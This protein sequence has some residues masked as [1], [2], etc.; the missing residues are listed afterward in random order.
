MPTWIK[1]KKD[2]HVN[3][4]Q[5]EVVDINS[6]SEMQ[7][8]AYNI[9]NAHFNN[10]SSDK[11]PLCLIIIGVA[12]T[13]K[14]YLINAIRNLLQNRCAV[15]A[16]TGKAAF[17]I[18]GVTIHSLLKLPIGSRG[19]KY[20]TGQSLCRLQENING[21][22]YIIIDEYSMLGQVTFGW[23]D[24]RCKQATGCYNKVLGGKSLILFGDPG[25]LPPVADKPLYHA[26]PSSAVGEQIYQT[27]RMFDKVVKLTVN[28]RVQGMSS[29]QVT[30][31]DLLLRLRK[32]ESTVDDWKLL[33]T[34]QPSAIPDLSEFEDS[35]R[36]FYSNEQ[37]ANYN[38]EELSKLERPVAHI[39]ARHSSAIAKKI[40]SEDMSGLEP[41]VFLAKG[42]RVMLT[43]N[44]WSSVGLCNEA[45]G[46]VIDFIFESN[47]QPPDLPVGVIVQFE[48][49]RGPS[50]D[51][52]RPSCVPICPITVSSQTEN[53][54][55]ERQQ[56][57]LRL[58]WALTIHKS[59][60]L[61]WIDIRKSERT[62]GVS[63]LA[64][65]R[66][67]T[68]SSCVIEPMTYERLTSLKSSANLQ[69]RLEEESRLDCLALITSSAFNSS[70]HSD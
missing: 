12:G 21:V 39:N 49:Y 14:S 25:Q 33:L 8:L 1:N 54:F 2:S 64:I 56:L 20:L 28:Q 70:D 17:N 19:K 7:G 37:V 46:T 6:F 38:H 52:T 18:K 60:G 29:E 45:T 59:Q 24:K 40:S 65:R 5:Y 68:L 27:Y 3:N 67:K 69:F 63:Y 53:G 13:G 11:E 61:T 55:H 34:R 26:K 50:F 51:D 32:A 57:P 23:V 41:V 48:N 30:F 66:V 9:V 31:R 62:A 15:T 35:T 43:M 44:L 16:T 58:A 10:I 42:A 47:H 36:L 4:E 22:E